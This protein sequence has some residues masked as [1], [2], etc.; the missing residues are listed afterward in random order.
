[1]DCVAQVLLYILS[2]SRLPRRIVDV[3]GWV[4]R[5]RIFGW[6]VRLTPGNF[7]AGRVWRDG[8]EKVGS[9]YGK[10]G[11]EIKEQRNSTR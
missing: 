8:N 9:R 2:D 10:G 3:H 1:M 4:Y 11:K 7:V 6:R 5:T